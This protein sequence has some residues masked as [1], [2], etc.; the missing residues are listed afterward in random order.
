MQFQS[1]VLSMPLD[2]PDNTETTALG[3]GYLAG[4][5]TGVYAD[6]DELARAAQDARRATSRGWTSSRETGLHERW[7]EAVSHARH[8]SREDDM[9]PTRWVARPPWSLCTSVP[10]PGPPAIERLESETFD[11]VVVGGGVVGTGCALD[12]ATRGLVDRAARGPRLGGRHQQPLQ[13][14]DPRRPALPRAAR[15]RAGPRGADGN[16]T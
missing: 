4:L 12:A 15:V 16:A 6:R 8:W 14:A 13:Q 9:S 10:T 5:A 11:V 7:T 2:V 1:D 3:S